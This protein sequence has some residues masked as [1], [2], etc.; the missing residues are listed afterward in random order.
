M[1]IE[2]DD[3]SIWTYLT[4]SENE[5]RVVM[6]GFI[7]STGTIV[8]KSSDALEFIN[9]GYAPPISEDFMNSFSIQKDL[10]AQDFRI[11]MFDN[12][13][14]VFIKGTSFVILDF[15]NSKS[16]SRSV[17]KPG[18]YGLPIEKLEE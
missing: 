13:V 6:D 7:C 11:E 4:D 10:Q 16:Y 12:K 2:E 14:I 9:K 17:S 18:P 1:I 15:I 8:K 5:N 3:Y